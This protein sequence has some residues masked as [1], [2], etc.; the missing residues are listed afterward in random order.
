MVGTS[1][2]KKDSGDNS[3]GYT[4]WSALAGELSQW[5]RDSASEDN[6]KYGLDSLGSNMSLANRRAGFDIAHCDP[7][8]FKRTW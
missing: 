1:G 6:Y 3:T 5:Y 4:V 8:C 2:V 7:N